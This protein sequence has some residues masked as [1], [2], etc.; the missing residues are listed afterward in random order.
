MKN[1]L[2][3]LFS[4]LS[5]SAVAQSPNFVFIL[6]DDMGWNGTSIQISPTVAGSISDF[7]ETP[8]LAQLAAS[9]MT[10][11]QAYSPAPNCAPT[12]NSILTG[13][14]PARNSFTTVGGGQTADRV[15]ISGT[16]NNSIDNGDITIA[17]WLNSTNL[18][19]RTAHYGKWHI[20]GGGPGDNGFS[21]HDGNNDNG[22]GD[23]ADGQIIQ[24]DPKKVMDLTNKGITFMQQAVAANEPFY[25]QLSH[26]AVHTSVET[27]QAAQDYFAAKP[28][29]NIHENVDYAGMTRDFDDAIGVLLNEIDNLNI[30]GETY[31]IFMS[32]NGAQANQSSNLPLFRSKGSIYEGGIRVPMIVRGPNIPANSTNP[33]PVVGYDLFPTIADWTGSSAALPSSLD[34]A[35]IKNLTLQTPFERDAPVYFHYPHYGNGNN[36]NPASVA[37]QDEYKLI[38]N[39]ESG[40][41]QLF[42]LN[43]NIRDAPANDIIATNPALALDLKIQLRDFL[44]EINAN[45]PSLDPTN[46]AFSGTAPDIDSDTLDDEWE[47]RELLSYHYG[48][49]DDPDGDGMDNLMEFNN[50]TDPLVEET[51]AIDDVVEFENSSFIGF[52]PNPAQDIINLEFRIDNA[53]N[54]I[55]EVEIYGIDGQLVRTF[56]NQKSTILSFDLSDVSSGIY[57]AKI[58]ENGQLIGSEKVILTNQK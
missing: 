7:Y 8:H 16:N 35:S 30:S 20:D 29:G 42:N 45:M 15:L 39:Y 56:K 52:Y 51:T 55:I 31:I 3:F 4:L 27:T 43:D 40:V 57:T 22:A 41:D 25:L 44:K 53:T 36:I 19:Y 11:S 50:G 18:N 21:H 9:G 34:G 13:E 17:E 33:E 12:R 24:N 32:D 26:Y 23:A 28:S 47:F 46:A 48:P 37:V 58:L 38:I 6:A 5:F 2:L 54:S 49:T 14:M 1:T 10:F